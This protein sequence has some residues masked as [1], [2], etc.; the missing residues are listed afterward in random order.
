MALF[1]F[2]W[3][4]ILTER[5]GIILRVIVIKTGTM[6]IVGTTISGWLWQRSFGLRLRVMCLR[7]KASKTAIMDGSDMILE[8][9]DGSKEFSTLGIKCARNTSTLE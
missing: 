6:G 1:P 7:I 4:L 3:W 5:V 8:S 2:Q 9:S